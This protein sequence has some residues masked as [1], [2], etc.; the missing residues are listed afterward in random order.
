M[1]LSGKTPTLTPRSGLLSSAGWIRITLEAKYLKR[2]FW[3]TWFC[4]KHKIREYGK[5]ISINNQTELD[6][7]SGMLWSGGPGQSS[8]GRERERER[9]R[10]V[11][12]P[13]QTTD[14]GPFYY[15]GICVILYGEVCVYVG[16]YWMS[17]RL[18]I[19]VLTY[20]QSDESCD[21]KMKPLSKALRLLWDAMPFDRLSFRNHLLNQS[22]EPEADQS[23]A[24]DLTLLSVYL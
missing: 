5:Q 9:E 22:K 15:I 20:F 7:N 2:L 18:C 23:T 6:R 11:N 14:V 24:C 13:Q 3:K 19:D 21:L 1:S 8:G 10:A 4:G 12:P 16:P 17:V